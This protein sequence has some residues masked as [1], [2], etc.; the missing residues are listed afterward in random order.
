MAKKILLVVVVL[1]VSSLFFIPVT[2]QNTILIKSPFLN[3]YSFLASPKKW[4][5]WRPDLRRYAAADSGGITIHNDSD[6]FTLNYRNLKLNVKHRENLFNIEEQNGEKT[7]S[8][9]YSLLPVPDKMMDKTL[10]SSEKSTNL[11]KYLLGKIWPDSLKDTRLYDL[12]AYLETDSLRYGFNITDG[13]VPAGSIIEL[14]QKVL[15]KNK[16]SAANQMFVSLGQYIKSHQIKQVQPVIAQFLP[17][18]NDSLQVNVGL[19]INKE[20][21]PDKPFHYVSMPK[22]GL[23]YIITYHGKF[24]KRYKV[25]KAGE[26]Y[27]NDKNRNLIVLPFETYLDNKLPASD[28]DQVNIQVNFSSLP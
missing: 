19:F 23:L 6:A 20:I 21:T 18:N 9:A 2:R 3:L 8:Y 22:G 25:Y 1:G 4:Q 10:V 14:K 16:F 11:A 26:Q 24:N 12:K 17:A 27:L 13:R 5:Q 28:T 15:A 7:L